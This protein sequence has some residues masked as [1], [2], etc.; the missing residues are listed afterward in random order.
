MTM[1]KQVC[2]SLIIYNQ[3]E[4]EGSEVL[5]KQKIYSELLSNKEL[6]EELASDSSGSDSEPSEDNLPLRELEP[7]IKVASSIKHL[8]IRKKHLKEI[9][10]KS[11]SFSSKRDMSNKVFGVPLRK[12]KCNNCGENLQLGHICQ[13][14][15]SINKIQAVARKNSSAYVN[16][17]GKRVRDQATQTVKI[18]ES[19]TLSP[20]EGLRVNKTRL[21]KAF[22]SNTRSKLAH[23]LLQQ[24]FLK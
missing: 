21:S 2:T 1:G 12:A 13:K 4:E 15:I 7:M 11:R 16:G 3:D 9:E 8:E 24:K 10:K 5:S 19:K 22:Q 23:E 18:E 20:H 17:N 14:K 6:L